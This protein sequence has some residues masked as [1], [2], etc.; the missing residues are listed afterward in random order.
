MNI[1]N[2]LFDEAA[3]NKR[4]RNA[5]SDAGRNKSRV[6]QL[7]EDLSVFVKRETIN[8]VNGSQID[9]DIKIG[10]LPSDFAKAISALK[11]AGT[12]PYAPNTQV[13]LIYDE[14]QINYVLSS[15]LNAPTDDFPVGLITNNDYN[16]LRQISVF[17]D[18]ITQITLTYYKQP[19]GIDYQGY[20]VPSQPR[21]G[22][23]VAAGKEIYSPTNS[24]DFELPEH[25]FAELVVEIAK[26]IGVNLRDQDV[27]SYS[28]NEE[29]TA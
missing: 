5:Q 6:K 10:L 26:L 14:E 21:F 4:I 28:V 29:K 8:L 11:Y 1:F 7:N 13:E 23:T 16:G 17:P 22:Y 20:K 15:N 12:S 9:E 3:L 24:V 18:S 27:Y 25:Y 2:K 19:E